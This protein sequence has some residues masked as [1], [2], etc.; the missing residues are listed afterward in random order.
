MVE[1]RFLWNH[2]LRLPIPLH[3]PPGPM[4]YTPRQ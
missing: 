1:Y 4:A 3:L 2:R